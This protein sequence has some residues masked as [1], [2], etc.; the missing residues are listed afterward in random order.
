MTHP[1]KLT[2][3]THWPIDPLFTL[4]PAFQ[5]HRS[6]PL[7][8]RLQ[9]SVRIHAH[10]RE[11]LAQGCYLKL[12]VMVS[13]LDSRLKQVSVVLLSAWKQ[14]DWN[15]FESRI[16]RTNHYVTTRPHNDNVDLRSNAGVCMV[17]K[18]DASHIAISFFDIADINAERVTPFNKKLSYRRV[19]ARCVLSVVILPIATQQCRNY[20]Y[21][22][23]WP[24]WWY[25]VG[26]LVGGNVSWT[27]CSQPWRDRVGSHCPRCRKQTDDG[28]VV[29]ITCIPTTC[30]GEI[31]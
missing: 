29:Y 12:N 15:L 6:E 22:K 26:G 21:D 30:C 17:W 3:L 28:R 4:F 24:N 31:F 20:L 10:V 19:T 27:M 25:E 13:A 7:T 16:Q 14:Y 8:V 18:N 1:K 11:Q 23:P 2:H 9:F 5:H